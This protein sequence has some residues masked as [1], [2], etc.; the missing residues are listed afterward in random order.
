MKKDALR[1]LIENFKLFPGVSVKYAEKMASALI[2]DEKLQKALTESVDLLQT[3]EKCPQ[4]GWLKEK[5]ETCENCS[6]NRL[7]LCVVEN[8]NDKSA[9]EKTGF[10]SGT[11]HILGGLISPLE[12]I[13][14]E[15]LL[16]EPLIENLRQEKYEEVF[17][18]L[19]ASLEGDATFHYII[20]ALPEVHVKVSRIARGLPSGSRPSQMDFETISRAVRERHNVSES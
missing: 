2:Q 1:K 19:P 12:G 4:C 16:I 10:F 18:A 11:F 7:S 6:S 15:N 20:E 9:I 3:I 13:L 5:N 8:F 14:P 17:F